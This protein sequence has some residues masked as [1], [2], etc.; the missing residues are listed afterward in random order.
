M[1]AKLK[2]LFFASG[3]DSIKLLHYLVDDILPSSAIVFAVKVFVPFKLYLYLYTL[4]I[5]M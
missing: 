1:A 3:I 5:C 4:R 2:D